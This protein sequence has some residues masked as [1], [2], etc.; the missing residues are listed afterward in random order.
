MTEA[1]A[2][3]VEARKTISELLTA[4]QTMIDELVESNQTYQ[5]S[6]KKAEEGLEFYKKMETN[7]NK[8][9][10]RLSSSV[11]ELRRKRE[12]KLGQYKKPQNPSSN[13]SG[14]MTLGMVLGGR[15]G[16]GSVVRQTYQ[17]PVPGQMPSGMM[18][19]PRMPYAPSGG[20]PQPQAYPQGGV[21][22][23]RPQSASQGYAPHVP[24][25]F[26]QNQ[27]RPQIS[28]G[29]PGQGSVNQ[30]PPQQTFPQGPPQ[31]NFAYPQR[32]PNVNVNYP[33]APTQMYQGPPQSNYPNMAPGQNY[34]NQPYAPT[35][36][37]P[38]FGS[39]GNQMYPPQNPAVSFPQSNFPQINPLDANN[40]QIG[41]QLLQPQRSDNSLI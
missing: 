31:N 15:G 20:P 9:S 24:A 5:D 32:Q 23:Y 36:Q 16:G 39:Q 3:F 29:Y 12:A 40:D 13:N 11:E 6:L 18:P 1:N 7:M 30:Y 35:T 4:R 2:N 26:Q 27:P 37:N 17:P 10:Q 8:L 28:Q 22:P 33:Q 14:K 34:P 25:P 19:Q 41:G 38:A 21:N